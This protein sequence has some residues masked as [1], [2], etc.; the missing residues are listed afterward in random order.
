MLKGT[1]DSL[2]ACPIQTQVIFAGCLSL[3]RRDAPLLFICNSF[4]IHPLHTHL[5]QPS[6]NVAWIESHTT[7]DTKR[8]D[9][10]T[11]CPSQD[12]QTADPEH[13][14]KFLRSQCVLYSVDPR[15]ERHD[16]MRVWVVQNAHF[17][18][19][20]K[21]RSTFSRISLPRAGFKYRMVDSK[22][23]CPSHS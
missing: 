7:A 11:L 22:S 14:R 6:C 12:G 16:P 3:S 18:S 13:L 9:S 19:G 20:A 4:L 17:A 21:V 2:L 5:H 23:L 10:P 1:H 8:R 15:R